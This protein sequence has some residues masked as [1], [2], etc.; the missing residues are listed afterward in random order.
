VLHKLGLN[1]SVPSESA[2]KAG[3]QYTVGLAASVEHKELQ[4]GDQLQ[5]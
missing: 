4:A 3:M 5:A 2:H 1:H